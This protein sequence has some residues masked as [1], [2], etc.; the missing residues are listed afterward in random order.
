MAGYE[1]S[2]SSPFQSRST[3]GRL[4]W[5]ELCGRVRSL[6]VLA[7]REAGETVLCDDLTAPATELTI[8]LPD[9]H[10]F[11]LQFDP[12][13]NRVVCEFPHCPQFNRTLELS[14]NAGSQVGKVTWTDLRTGAAASHDEI[15]GDLVRNLLIMTNDY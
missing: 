13:R 7:N 3:R 10:G 8:H 4:A 5:I 9:G 15:A 2:G 1:K 14:A 11:D 12:D 6:V